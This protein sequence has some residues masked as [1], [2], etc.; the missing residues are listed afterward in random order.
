ML[1]KLD[2]R[3]EEYNVR[4]VVDALTVYAYARHKAGRGIERCVLCFASINIHRSRTITCRNADEEYELN[5]A[6]LSR[7]PNGTVNWFL[8]SPSFGHRS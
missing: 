1:R 7:A 3:L 8:T 5:K 2:I 6:E 4:T